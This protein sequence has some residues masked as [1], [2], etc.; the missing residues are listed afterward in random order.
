MIKNSQLEVG[1]SHTLFPKILFLEFDL[2][3]ADAEVGEENRQFTKIKFY[4]F[5]KL[6]IRSS[7]LR[8]CFD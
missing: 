4:F 6:Q 8:I 2:Q 3:K 7:Y 1:N 5:S